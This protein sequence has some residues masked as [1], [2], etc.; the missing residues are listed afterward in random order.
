MWVGLIYPSF[1]SDSTITDTVLTIQDPCKG[2]GVWTTKFTDGLEKRVFTPFAGIPETIWRPAYL[3]AL[4]RLRARS[5]DEERKQL[6]KG[7][8]S[9][10]FFPEGNVSFFCTKAPLQRN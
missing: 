4:E 8:M 6:E 2:I 3:R 9:H 1:A 10:S 7:N 5:K